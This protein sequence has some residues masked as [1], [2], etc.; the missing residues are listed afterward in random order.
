[1]NSNSRYC[2]CHFGCLV[3]NKLKLQLIEVRICN[4]GWC[5]T[6]K[7]VHP[8]TCKKDS[9]L[10]DNMPHLHLQA[11]FPTHTYLFLLCNL[12]SSGIWRVR[13]RR[14]SEHWTVQPCCSSGL[15]TDTCNAWSGT[16]V[17]ETGLRCWTW[18]LGRHWGVAFLLWLRS[19]PA[20][21]GIT[22]WIEGKRNTIQRRERPSNI[23]KE[24]NWLKSVLQSRNLSK[25]NCSLTYQAAT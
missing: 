14:G 12:F 5:Y 25:C 11:K 13:T 19:K 23:Y 6:L 20:D 15:S 7:C 3:E 16:L 9:T 17:H 1:M 21:S 10:I 24:W 4:F 2:W 18:N 22:F 8:G